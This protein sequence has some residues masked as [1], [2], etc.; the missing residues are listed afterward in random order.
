M[1]LW[2]FARRYRVRKTVLPGLLP[3]VWLAA[4]AISGVNASVVCGL[5]SI[6]WFIIPDSST[7]SE[8]S[9][10]LTD[11]LHSAGSIARGTPFN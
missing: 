10:S 1:S 3:M 7:I 2:W 11:T 9:T 5:P 8:C 6:I 4:T